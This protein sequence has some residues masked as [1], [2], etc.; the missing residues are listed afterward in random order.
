MAIR[1]FASDAEN[2]ARASGV[3]YALNTVGAAIG[4]LLAGFVLIP[5]IGLSGTTVVGVAAS[6]LAAACVWMLAR[7]DEKRGQHRG[8]RASRRTEETRN[9]AIA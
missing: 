6:G 9:A 3:L 1:W 5:A 7:I 8:R 4:A 2:P